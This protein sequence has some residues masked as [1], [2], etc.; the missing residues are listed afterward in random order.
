[1]PPCSE[2]VLNN[3]EMEE[4]AAIVRRTP[5]LYVISDEVYKYTVYVRARHPNIRGRVSLVA[6]C[7]CTPNVMRFAAP[8][9]VALPNCMSPHL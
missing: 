9:N 7:P 8:H 1:M 6:A 5:G 2:V 3:A 4:L